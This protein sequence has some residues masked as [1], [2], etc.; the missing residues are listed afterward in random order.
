M[1]LCMTLFHLKG[2][3]KKKVPFKSNFNST[4]IAQLVFIIYN[5]SMNKSNIFFNPLFLI[6]GVPLLLIVFIVTLIYIPSWL[7][8]PQYNF[9]YVSSNSLYGGAIDNFFVQDGKIRAYINPSEAREKL[10]QLQKTVREYN[11][12]QKRLQDI[13]ATHFFIFD[14][15]KRIASPISFDTASKLRVNP[16][17]ASPDGYRIT[18]SRHSDVIFF[19][20][21]Y[22]G[23]RYGAYIL[24]KGF[25]TIEL[26]MRYGN[27]KFLGWLIN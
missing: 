17:V 3:L 12:E 26:P 21:F 10:S 6:V 8:S 11:V 22:G 5:G 1:I 9:V 24:K 13:I 23:S 20:F 18:R 16:S 15:K 25:A 2:R 4:T 7:S 19:P 14:V 27:T